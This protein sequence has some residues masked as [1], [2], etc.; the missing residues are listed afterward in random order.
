MF[1]C[2]AVHNC[3]NAEF[4]N[5]DDKSQYLVHWQQTNSSDIFVGQQLIR[6]CTKLYRLVLGIP[7]GTYCA[8]LVADL[9]SFCYK[10]DFM[11]ISRWILSALLTLHLEIWML[12]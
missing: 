8:P 12:F 9:F 1:H 7:K 6:F 3:L 11:L 4:T 5:I 10:M 2:L